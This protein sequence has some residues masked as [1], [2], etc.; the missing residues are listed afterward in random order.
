MSKPPP[1][2]TAEEFRL[3]RELDDAER[4][5]AGL[6]ANHDQHIAQQAQLRTVTA[7]RDRHAAE[8]RALRAKARE[9]KYGATHEERLLAASIL[10]EMLAGGGE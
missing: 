7:E 2:P 5:I 10:V 4:T 3:R 6:R 1:I 9:A 8:L